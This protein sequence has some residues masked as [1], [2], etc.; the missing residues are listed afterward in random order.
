M[1][2]RPKEAEEKMAK[3][4]FITGNG[5]LAV[6]DL[7]TPSQLG[8]GISMISHRFDCFVAEHF[9]TR[10]RTLAFFRIRRKTG[11]N[12]TNQMEIVNCRGKPMPIP[13]IQLPPKVIA[14]EHISISYI[15]QNVIAFLNRFGQLFAVCPIH[16]SINTWSDRILKIIL[17]NIW[18]MFAK[19]IHGMEL[20]VR[21]FRRLRKF[22]PTILND[23]RPSLRVVSF[24]AEDMFPEFP[25]D[26]SAAASNGQAVAKWL[27]TP[28]Q[29]D[30]PKML[31]CGL[32]TDNLD[33]FKATFASASSRINF[34]VVIWFDDSAMPFVLTNKLTQE[35]LTLKRT[36]YRNCFLLIRCPI[37]RDESKWTKWEEEAIDWRIYNRWN[38]IGI[39]I[40]DE[41]QIGKGLLDATPGPSDQQQK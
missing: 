5:W 1:S 22:V 28:L 19:N 6:F 39:Q 3:A 34:I 17:R 41:D 25:A 7:L 40:N 18:P 10:K 27:L 36:E 30:V 20:P 23:C 33:A 15:D 21:I 35:Q 14:F 8:L 37:V 16:L 32:D 13:H 2:D 24:D 31:K 9:K 38:R 11:E 12:G 29:S 4:I 26:D